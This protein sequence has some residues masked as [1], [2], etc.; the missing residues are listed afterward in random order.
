MNIEKL[1]YDM[2]G[3][4]KKVSVGNKYARQIV[5]MYIYSSYDS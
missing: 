2:L 5:L 4:C 3:S 1:E